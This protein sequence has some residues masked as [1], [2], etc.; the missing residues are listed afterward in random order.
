MHCDGKFLSS[1]GIKC[2]DEIDDCTKYTND[3]VCTDCI[4]GKIPSLDGEICITEIV[5]YTE[6]IT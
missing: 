6:Y 2:I 1:N 4:D 5:S 3:S